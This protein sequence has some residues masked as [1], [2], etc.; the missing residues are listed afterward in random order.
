METHER[1]KCIKNN[2][3][4]LYFE[5]TNL[6]QLQILLLACT[7][8]EILDYSNRLSKFGQEIADKKRP[9]SFTFEVWE[10]MQNAKRNSCKND[11]VQTV[12]GS[13][14]N[15]LSTDDNASQLEQLSAN[16]NETHVLSDDEVNEDD[17]DNLFNWYLF[18]TCQF[19]QFSF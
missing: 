12:D 10:F 7:R 8:S 5:I 18:C 14:T 1:C 13:T 11:P 17:E 3:L 4:Y 15:Q 19:P 16:G 2:I 9:N 6:Q